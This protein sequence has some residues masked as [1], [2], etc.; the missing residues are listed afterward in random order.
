MAREGIAWLSDRSFAVQGKG[1]NAGR[2]LPLVAGF[3]RADVDLEQLLLR[4]SL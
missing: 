2:G 4:A 1:W 3:L